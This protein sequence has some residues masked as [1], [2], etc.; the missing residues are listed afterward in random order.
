MRKGFDFTPRNATILQMTALDDFDRA[1]LREVQTDNRT[2]LRD[3]GARVHLSAA[4][5]QRRLRRMERDGVIRSNTAVLDPRACGAL[6]TVVVE[7]E[8]EREHSAS[9]DRMKA[10]L[11][12]APQIQ[13]CYYVTGRT[14]FMLVVVVEDMEAYEVFIAEQFFDDPDIKRFESFVVMDQVKSGLTI[15]LGRRE[16]RRE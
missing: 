15:D 1:I 16:K 11:R 7:V 4:A 9:I 10:R 6:I 8:L 12:A 2:P 5:V 13:Q 14:D 3:I